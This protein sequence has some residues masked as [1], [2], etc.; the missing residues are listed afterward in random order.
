ML[1]SSSGK[2][3]WENYVVL[4]SFEFSAMT[5]I[6]ALLLLLI[7]LSGFGKACKKA[8]VTPPVETI[9]EAVILG[10][11]TKYLSSCYFASPYQFN[12]L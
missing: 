1:E 6:F 11:N 4:K 12:K 2:I 9:N 10:S 8:S 5:I 7:S 3:V